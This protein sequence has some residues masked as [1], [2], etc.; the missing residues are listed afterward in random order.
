[1]RVTHQDTF[2]PGAPKKFTYDDLKAKNEE[3]K[4]EINLYLARWK[5]EYNG[6]IA[7]LSEKLTKTRSD[8]DL[9]TQDYRNK[10]IGIGMGIEER[11]SEIIF[12]K[13]QSERTIDQVISE[14]HF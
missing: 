1:M 13:V 10:K 4:S 3:V 5:D 8:R 6:K 14:I 2:I 7:V 9:L 11:I 12:P